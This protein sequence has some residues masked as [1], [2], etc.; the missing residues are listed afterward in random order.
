MF[1]CLAVFI[2][3]CSSRS[4]V[5]CFWLVLLFLQGD[6][7]GGLTRRWQLHYTVVL[8]QLSLLKKATGPEQS[9][10]LF[11]EVN[12]TDSS[13]CAPFKHQTCY[14]IC[15]HACVCVAGQRLIDRIWFVAWQRD[16]GKSHTTV[17]FL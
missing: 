16:I 7:L 13:A 4:L 2:R 11:S 8:L 5:F 9:H 12:A 15:I 1:V 3:F 10:S 17:G 14:A 6:R